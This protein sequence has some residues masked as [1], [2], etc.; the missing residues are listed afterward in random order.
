MFASGRG[1]KPITA[2]NRLI[3]VLEWLAEALTMW[4][5]PR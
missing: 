1:P 5:L 4:G 3:V 2:A